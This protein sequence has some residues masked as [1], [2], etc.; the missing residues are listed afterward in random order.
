MNAVK[1]QVL[2]NLKVQWKAAVEKQF[3]E[4]PDKVRNADIHKNAKQIMA[5]PIV[6]LASKR[7]GITQEDIKGVLMEIRNEVLAER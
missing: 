6:R 5:N 3:K 2:T 7:A 4:E 1:E